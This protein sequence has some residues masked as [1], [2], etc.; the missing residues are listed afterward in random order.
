MR[1]GR[2]FIRELGMGERP[3]ARGTRL[4]V[5][6]TDGEVKDEVELLVKLAGVGLVVGEGYR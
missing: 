6:A 3:A 4:T 2:E 5:R 1:V